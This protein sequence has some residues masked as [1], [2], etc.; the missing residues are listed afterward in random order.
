MENGEAMEKGEV[1]LSWRKWQAGQTFKGCVL[2]LGP[3]C[4]SSLLAG[5]HEVI[6]HALLPMRYCFTEASQH[7]PNPLKPCGEGKPSSSSFFLAFVPMM[8]I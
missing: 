8:E 2:A 5:S 7:G 4:Y 6:H 1:G 3:S